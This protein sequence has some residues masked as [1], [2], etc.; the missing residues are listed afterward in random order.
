M[1]IRTDLQ[2][3]ESASEITD[4]EEEF[5]AQL[6]RKPPTKQPAQNS[7]QS[8]SDSDSEPLGEDDDTANPSAENQ[9]EDGKLPPRPKNAIKR[10]LPRTPYALYNVEPVLISSPEEI[11]PLLARASRLKAAHLSAFLFHPGPIVRTRILLSSHLRIEGLVYTP[12]FLRD[13]PRLMLFWTEYLLRTRALK[14]VER[15][16]RGA[17]DISKMAVEELIRTGVVCK[18]IPDRVGK[19]MKALFG[20]RWRDEED[21]EKVEKVKRFEEALKAENVEFM[22]VKDLTLPPVAPDSTSLPIG[23][24]EEVIPVVSVDTESSLAKPEP[25]AYIEEIGEDERDQLPPSIDV[26]NSDTLSDTPALPETLNEIPEDPSVGTTSE[27]NPA[28]PSF[29]IPIDESEAP[30]IP[31]WDETRDPEADLASWLDAPNQPLFELMGPTV[32]PLKFEAGGPGDGLGPWTW[33]V[34]PATAD[35]PISKASS[36]PIPIR[37]TKRAFVEKSMRRVKSI[38]LPGVLSPA[39]KAVAGYVSKGVELQIVERLARIVLEPW[40]DWD[41]EG[42][43]EPAWSKPRVQRSD[44]V[45]NVKER[46]SGNEGDEHKDEPPIQHDPEK[47]EILLLVDPDVLQTVFVGMGIAGTWVQLVRVP[48]SPLAPSSGPSRG[49]GGARTRGQGRG[50][51]RGGGGV[52]GGQGGTQERK[53]L[54]WWYVED[55]YMAIPSYWLLGEEIVLPEGDEEEGL[56]TEV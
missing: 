50:R 34:Q 20:V 23:T 5:E 47:D 53:Q 3:E 21:I 56:E 14:E 41:P 2:Q 25:G 48:S 39:E 38:H 27:T 40:V 30:A 32:L 15:E 6:G 22:D 13:I 8:F 31:K 10:V 29:S 7:K 11:P 19:G 55:V 42:K 52:A 24:E 37:T 44:P 33:S 4:D 12:S 9:E 28:Y 45:N 35:D 46:E 36:A 51:G 1:W 18:R 43:V 26:G 16:L 54:T 17:R 49:R